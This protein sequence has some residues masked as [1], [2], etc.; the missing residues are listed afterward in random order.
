MLF[1]VP[2][3]SLACMAARADYL[4]EFEVLSATRLIASVEVNETFSR[5]KRQD[6]IVFIECHA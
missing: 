3:T 5:A 4:E 1:E 2:N 6:T